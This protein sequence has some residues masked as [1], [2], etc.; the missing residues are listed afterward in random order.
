MITLARGREA[1]AL[2]SIPAG[3]EQFNAALA[4]EP[5]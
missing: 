3:N 2:A 4:G 1:A 5:V